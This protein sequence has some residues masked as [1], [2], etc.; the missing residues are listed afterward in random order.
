MAKV[1]EEWGSV[2]VY[3]WRR[4]GWTFRLLRSVRIACSTGKARLTGNM[5][6]R[7]ISSSEVCDMT[8]AYCLWLEGKVL[9]ESQDSISDEC[10]SDSFRFLAREAVRDLVV[11]SAPLQKYW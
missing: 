1:G 11:S 6:S 2:A 9:A 5:L 10:G 3:R 8:E 4:S 7:S